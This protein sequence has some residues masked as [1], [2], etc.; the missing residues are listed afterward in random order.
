MHTQ[1]GKEGVDD[2]RQII[3]KLHQRCSMSNCSFESRVFYS[4]PPPVKQFWF[5]GI[6]TRTTC[7]ISS[8]GANKHAG[9]H[10][11]TSHAAQSTSCFFVV[12]FIY[13]FFLLLLFLWRTHL[14]TTKSPAVLKKHKDKT[15]QEQFH[16]TQADSPS[17]WCLSRSRLAELWRQIH[18]ANAVYQRS[19]CV[20]N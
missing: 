2:G 13:V 12:I 10:A 1:T 16:S 4:C 5:R 14:A 3:F 6:N 8:G 9:K 11:V 20:A 17:H 19:E 15:K 18:Y 7:C